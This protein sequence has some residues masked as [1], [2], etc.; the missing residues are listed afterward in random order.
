MPKYPAADI[1]IYK[2]GVFDLAGIHSTIRSW[3]FKHK[4]VPFQ[5]V[6]K[7]KPGDPQGR[8]IIDDWKAKRKVTGYIVYWMGVEIKGW[9][10]T[11]VE[12]GAKKAKRQKGRI[13]VRVISEYET[14]WEKRFGASPFL[15]KMRK[16]YENYIIKKDLQTK[17][18]AELF[19]LT[20]DL[21]GALKKL[22]EVE[23][24]KIG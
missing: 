23:A 3:C 2:S 12:V 8:Q 17:Y 24:E 1:Y 13:R 10:I 5:T 9:D 14:D 6:F 15:E 4:F 18:E 20:Y 21:H 22:L 11:D 16:F 19:G 7:D